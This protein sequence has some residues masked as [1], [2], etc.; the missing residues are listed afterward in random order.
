MS[1]VFMAC[2]VLGC[3]ILSNTLGEMNDRMLGD[4]YCRI[5]VSDWILSPCNS[6]VNFG[7]DCCLPSASYGMPEMS[8]FFIVSALSQ[9][10]SGSRVHSHTKRES[11]CRRHRVEVQLQ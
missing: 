10:A 1:C 4:F 6:V 7:N 9:E 11:S 5:R 8:H 2:L 3:M